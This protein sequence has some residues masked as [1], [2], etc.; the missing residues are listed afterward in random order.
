MSCSPNFP[1]LESLSLELKQVALACGS[2][3][4]TPRPHLLKVDMSQVEAMPA[5]FL[6]NAPRLK[7]LNV[8]HGTPHSLFGRITGL[9]PTHET[10]WSGHAQTGVSSRT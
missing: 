1:K 2:L 7:R 9:S 10:P 6:A 3:M 4:Q 8:P 5:G